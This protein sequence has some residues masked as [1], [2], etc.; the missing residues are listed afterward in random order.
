MYAF[1]Y[2]P[3]PK[4]VEYKSPVHKTIINVLD[5]TNG[6]SDYLRGC[7]YLAH[8]AAQLKMSF[9]MDMTHHHIHECMAETLPVN[10]L[11][12]PIPVFMVNVQTEEH[13]RP[14]LQKFIQSNESTMYMTTNFFYNK[15]LITEDM[16][17]YINSVFT[18]KP[19][20]YEMATLLVP[21]QYQVLHIRC[22]DDHFHTAFE[23]DYLFAEIIKLQLPE[24]TIVL[25]NNDSLKRKIHQLFG[26]PFIDTE[27]VHS[28]KINHSEDLTSTILDYIILS[29]STHTYCFSYYSH[30]SG[31]SE[32]CSFLHNVPYQS[33]CVDKSANLKML[34]IY[35]NDRWEGHHKTVPV[36]SFA[37]YDHVAFITLTNT[38]Y[39]DYTL[40]C[41]ESLQKINMPKSL[42]AY[43]IGEEG[44]SIL[45]KNNIACELIQD[46]EASTFQEF[47]KNKWS[48]VTYYKFEIIHQNLL[49]HEYVCI[50]DGDIV[51]EQNVF[52]YLLSNIEDNDM[53]IQ[54]EGISCD[55]LCSGFM[56]IK[57]NPTTRS[58]FNPES[59]KKYRHVEGWDD[60]VYVNANKYKMKF[61]KLPI[62]L[63]P[64]GKYFYEYSHL[65]QPYLIHFNWI[66]GHEKKE[67]MKTYHK[68][69][70]VPKIK[71]NICQFGTD[72][73]G[74]QLE[75]TLRLLSL[76]L[77]D[78][79]KYHY[80]DKKMYAFEHTNFDMQ[81]LQKYFTHA[82][83][84]LSI[85]H[86]LPKRVVL[87][88]YR[89]FDKIIASD[90]DYETTLYCYDGVS[91]NIPH[92]LPPNVESIQ[93]V[94]ASLPK[95]RDAF[96]HTGLPVPSYKRQGIQV[97]CHL[98]L[99]DAV[100]NRALDTEKL[101]K[102]I[103][104]FQSYSKYSVTIHTNG[105]A[106]HLQSDNTII[107][108][109]TT[110]VLQ[111]LSDFIH[112]DVLIINHS[113]LSIAAHLLA[114]DTQ[115]VVAPNHIHTLCPH[116]ILPK[117]VTT[118]EFFTHFKTRIEKCSPP[119]FL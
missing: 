29:K 73:F 75:G 78:Q 92:H 95:L 63:F 47:R 117:C 115:F 69:Y 2:K 58:I 1:Q 41:L 84:R 45:K 101:G 53:L 23:D 61:K 34:Y 91:S 42:K 49:T 7:L 79:A 87:R 110:N 114:K 102:V 48:N 98:R 22:T 9:L 54:S 112:A 77:N 46:K 57:S 38:G 104:E 72:G 55:D 6:V 4:Q 3:K 85:P 44:Y 66:V 18:F 21:L 26:F 74:H 20:Y 80:D 8:V 109:S 35:Y 68:W 27:S 99:G 81:Q 32:Q 19:K 96:V 30:G 12:S 76:S 28:A 43:C 15:N 39:L 64:T 36:K 86:V 33:I 113:S 83:H 60:Q 11:P 97:C 108:G 88:E 59:I 56:F 94:S 111:V 14:V 116:R 119:L 16:K 25:S 93:Q 40:N 90:A 107:H 89:T 52:D 24:N 17:K 67:K 105:D 51:Y 62:K 37:S 10:T 100:G 70:M 65:V 106:S 31:F 82:L 118:D 13:L 50:T 103:Q 71:L 5:Y